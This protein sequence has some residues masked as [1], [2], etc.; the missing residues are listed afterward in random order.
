M[1]IDPARFGGVNMLMRSDQMEIEPPFA[2]RLRQCRLDSVE[3]V[4]SHVDGEIVA[5]SRTT[6]TFRV[7]GPG[8]EPGF[9]VKRYLYPTWRKRL[10]SAFRGTLLGVHRA[11]SEYRGLRGLAQAGVPVARAVAVGSRRVA[12]FVTACFLITEAVPAS[13]NLTS[14]AQ[15]VAGGRRQISSQAR[16]KIA[17]SLGREVA[18]LHA[19]GASHGQLFWRN[20][21]IRLGLR[22]TPDFFFLDVEPYSRLE[23]VGTL[24]TWW[25]RELAQLFASARPFASRGECVRFLQAYLDAPSLNPE[26]RELAREVT[27]LAAEHEQHERQRIRMSG[28]FDGWQRKLEVEQ[29]APQR[30]ADG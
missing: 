8:R 9:Y 7:A 26:Q 18:L 10:R 2:D 11:Q 19:D 6:D 20:I 1:S 15:S 4:L 30:A 22:E 21:L 13:E 5:W 16:R 24:R 28:L 29:A 17:T 14:F 12:G 27:R 25:R 3:R 23:R